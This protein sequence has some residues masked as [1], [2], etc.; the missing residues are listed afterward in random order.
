[1]SP[2]DNTRNGRQRWGSVACRGGII[3]LLT[4]AVYLPALRGGFIWD[5]D[6][7][8]T[9]NAAMDS[10]SGLRQIW[11]SLAVSRYYP[12]TLT[13]FWVEHRCWGLNPLP[14][15][16]VNI[17][18][19]A[20]NAVLL[21]VL[22]RR[23]QVRGAWL[24]AAFW[25]VHPVNVET[26]AWVTELKNT[27]SGFF[28]LLALLIFLRFEDG[29]RWRDYAIALLCGVAAM[30]SKPSTVVL[31]GVIL[32]CAWWRRGRWTRNDLFRIAP[33]VML[34]VG[35]SLLTLLEQRHHIEREYAADWTMTAVQRL[36]LAGRAVWFYAWK[37]LWPMNLCFIYPRWELQVNDVMAW[38]PLGGLA[39]GAGM[40]WRFRHTGWG[41][42]LIFGLG[43]FI[44]AL[45]PVLG[46][47]DIYFFRYSFVGDHFQYLASIGL[48]SLIVGGSEAICERGGRWGRDA[49]TVAATAVLFTLGFC[50]WKQTHVYHDVETL[51]RDTLAKNP[52]A[53]L[54]HNNL[55]F[56][57][58]YTG[59]I[60]EAIGHYHEALRLKPDVVEAHNNLGIALSESG[61]VTEGIK[62]YKEGLRVNPRS[63]EAHYNLG[64]GLRSLGRPAEAVEEYKLALQYRPA[65][66]EAHNNLGLALEDLGKPAEA[67]EHY[68]KALRLEPDFA[69]AYNNLG[70]IEFGL[71]RFSEAVKEYERSLQAR[72]DYAEARN[73]L[74]NALSNLG[75]LN[76]AIVQYEQALL[77][78]PDYPEAHF[79]LGVALEQAGRV[80]EAIGHYQQALR[81][82]PDFEA[83]RNRL[84]QLRGA[85]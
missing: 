33:F 64:N 83:A 25:A 21:W 73:N 29:Q 44:V 69:E 77:L 31:P 22:L 48:V 49:G 35:M 67:R 34:A 10:L 8:L 13:T 4:I 55:G 71:G 72:P 54:A 20:V 3:C 28:F 61:H 2:S 26:V 75:R 27:Q 37:L 18:L 5:D 62:E 19:H 6:D 23:L 40:L 12:L 56:A 60:D 1:M 59:R 53:W 7:H 57:L 51:W 66:P 14:Y 58:E 68:E 52:N 46:F 17:A 39:A 41:R 65:Y 32:L 43:Y 47:F 78:R 11:S 15:H 38:V 50:T 30:L 36:I 24:A 74:G 84:V 85:H 42:A 82:K 76:E 79:D 45:L 9:R 81:L 70:N 80:P 63:P 16:A